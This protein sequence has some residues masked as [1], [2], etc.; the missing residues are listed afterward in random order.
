MDVFKG[1]FKSCASS[2]KAPFR[3]SNYLCRLCDC[4]PKSWCCCWVPSCPQGFGRKSRSITLILG[5]LD[6]S[7]RLLL[8]TYS[9]FIL[10]MAEMAYIP[11][12]LYSINWVATLEKLFSSPVITHILLTL[13]IYKEAGKK[14]VARLTAERELNSLTNSEHMWEILQAVI[15]VRGKKGGTTCSGFETGWCVQGK[16]ALL[17]VPRGSKQKIQIQYFKSV[18]LSI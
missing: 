7:A 16:V 11:S 14:P 6:D 1:C 17:Y 18:M 10:L 2:Q 5:L 4:V 12:T 3:I 8:L 9:L 15:A 13:S